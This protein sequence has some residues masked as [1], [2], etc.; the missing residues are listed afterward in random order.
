MEILPS[1]EQWS[2]SAQESDE[3]LSIPKP[4]GNVPATHVSPPSVVLA[5][6]PAVGSFRPRASFVPTVVQSRLEEQLSDSIESPVRIGES[7]NDEPPLL[8]DRNVAS[9]GVA[10]GIPCEA[11]PAQ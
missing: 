7:L 2:A 4:A 6:T 5:A 1:T 8:V 3:K 11:R 9:I 10:P